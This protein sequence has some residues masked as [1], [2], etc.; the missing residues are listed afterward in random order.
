MASRQRDPNGFEKTSENIRKP[1]DDSMDNISNL[2]MMPSFHGGNA[3]FWMR[4]IRT[5]R[6]FLASV[7]CS[8]SLFHRASGRRKASLIALARAGPA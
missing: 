1:D 6:Y 2:A 8:N 3:R 5:A 4:V 7:R